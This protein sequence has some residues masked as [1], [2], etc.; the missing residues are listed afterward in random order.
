[1]NKIKKDVSIVLCPYENNMFFKKVFN[2][3]INTTD[4]DFSKI[5][6]IVV[7]NNIDTSKQIDICN[8]LEQYID[9]GYTIKYYSNKNIKQLAGATNKAIELSDSKWFIYLCA[10]DTYIYHNGWLNN[11]IENL[12]DSDYNN[13]YRIGGTISSWPNYFS[14]KSK[15]IHVQGSIFIS[16][17]E[18]MK[19]NKYSDKY[20]F[21][22]MDVYHSADCLKKGYK[23]KGIQKVLASMG[24]VS[25]KEHE[26]I[27]KSKKYFITHLHGNN[28][29]Y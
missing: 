1:M 11:L 26:D 17:T 29:F 2:Q 13:G 20:P 14:D 9:K 15:H 21:S 28:A 6:F 18:Y 25:T 12:S 27:K 5:E 3:I 10:T 23:L 16:F 22:F 8:F 4:Y 7:D 24:F 19:K